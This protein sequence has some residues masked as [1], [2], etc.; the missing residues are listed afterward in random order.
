M[1]PHHGV[2]GITFCVVTGMIFFNVLML[3][4]SCF[5]GDKKTVVLLETMPVPAV[6]EHSKWFLDDP[7]KPTGRFFI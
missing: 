2:K 7:S 6:L 5:A 1:K 3:Y 4:P